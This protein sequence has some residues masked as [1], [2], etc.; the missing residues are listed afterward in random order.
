MPDEWPQGIWKPKEDRELVPQNIRVAVHQGPD[1]ELTA[2]ATIEMD[3]L[4]SLVG[5]MLNTGIFNLT[6]YFVKNVNR[7]ILI[8][9]KIEIFMSLLYQK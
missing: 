6:T 9:C 1:Q 4:Q 2:L 8:L 5:D 7:Q 3:D